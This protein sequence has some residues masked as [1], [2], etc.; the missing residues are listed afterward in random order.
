M[1]DHI[2]EIFNHF[3]DKNILILGDVMIDAYLFGKVDRISPEAPV[4]VVTLNNRENRL[5]GAANVALNIQALGANPILC[6]VIG[7][8]RQGTIFMKLLQDNKLNT[9]GMIISEERITTT[10]FR[11]IGNNAQMLRVDEEHTHDLSS[12]EEDS[13]FSLIKGIID[14]READA[15]ILQDYNKGVLTSM[16]LSQVIS[17]AREKHISVCADPKKKNFDG[18]KGVTLFKPNLKELKEG[19]KMD[20]D[21]NDSLQLESA[22]S[23]LQTRQNIDMV[24]V[25]LSENGVIIRSKTG[26][27]DYEVSRIPAHRRSIADVSGAGDTVISVAALCLATACKPA[28]LAALSN[29]AGGLVCEEVGVVPVNK[30]RLIKEAIQSNIIF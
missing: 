28:A 8:D 16:I 22:I 15:I 14:R 9:S 21:Q 26:A 29:L 4:P 1:N 19:L 24:L 10:K 3:R 27:D 25:T 18:F 11:V 7:N 20:F 5:G 6:S 2:T 12:K 17:L 23:I 13:Y 30:E